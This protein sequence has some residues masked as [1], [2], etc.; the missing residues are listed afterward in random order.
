MFE[1]LFF[2]TDQGINQIY[3]YSVAVP[4]TDI[5]AFC[6]F[7]YFILQKCVYSLNGCKMTVAG[8]R[9]LIATSSK[10]SLAQTRHNSNS[11]GTWE[12]WISC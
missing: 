9:N 12:V 8:I 6:F 7:K 4:F 5:T 11:P 10:P 1:T 2:K 3:F